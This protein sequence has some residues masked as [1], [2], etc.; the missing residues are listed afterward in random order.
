MVMSA[1]GCGRRK[2]LGLIAQAR[3]VG[4][5]P[6]AARGVDCG[7]VAGA[8]AGPTVRRMA[9]GPAPSVGRGYGSPLTAAEL[10]ARGHGRRERPRIARAA[11]PPRPRRQASRAVVPPGAA[12][13]VSACLASVRSR[14]SAGRPRRRPSPRSGCCCPAPS[15]RWPW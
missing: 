9:C 4:L 13:A 2:S 5:L 7:S 14:W 1:T 3:G 11:R 8:R 6:R 12:R 10:R 15:H